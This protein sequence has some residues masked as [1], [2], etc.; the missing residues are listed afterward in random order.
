METTREEALKKIEELVAKLGRYRQSGLI[1]RTG[2]EGTKKDF[3]TPLFRALGWDVENDKS[4]DEVI[5]EERVSK[6]RVD[7]SFRINGIP[8]FFLEAKA[9][10]K[11]LDEI[12]DSSQAINYAWHKGTS[13]AVLTDFQTLVIY[14]AEVKDNNLSNA[15]FKTLTFDQFVEHFE[16]LWLLSKPAFD[17]GLLDKAA[18]SWGKK[19]RK[20]KVGDQ[21]LSELMRHRTLLSKNIVKNNASKNLS[22]AEVDEAVQRIIDRLIFIRTAEDRNIEPPTLSPLVREIEDKKRGKAT[23]ALNGVYRKFD[24]TYNSKLFTFNASDLTQRHLCETLEIDNDTLLQVIKGLYSSLDGLTH[25]DFSAID[26][27]VLGNIYEQYLSHILK[28]TDKRAKVENREAHRKEQGIYYTPTYIVDYIV[29]NTLGEMLKN[30]KPAEADKLKVLDMA[31]GSGSFLLKAFDVLDEYYK[32]KDKNYAQSKLDART[33]ASRITRKTQILRNNIYGVD[34]D[35]KAVEI[36]QLNLLLKAAETRHRLPDLRENVKCGNSLID[37]PAIAGGRAFNWNDEFPEIM[38]DGGFDVIVGNPPYGAELKSAEMKYLQRKYPLNAGRLDT[39]LLFIE[40]AV[41]C[42]K[43]G[44]YLGFIVPV[45]WIVGTYSRKLREYLLS[46]TNIVQI[47]YFSSHVFSDAKIDTIIIILKKTRKLEHTR[48]TFAKEFSTI[49]NAEVHF[50]QEAWL[51]GNFEFYIFLDTQSKKLI[52]KMDT[53]GTRLGNLTTGFLGIQAY[54]KSTDRI[55]LGELVS[56]EGGIGF[57]PE[58]S[59]EHFNR[60]ALS[61]PSN[62]YV[63]YCNELY[64]ARKKTDFKQ[65]KILVRRILKDRIIAALDVE[66][67]YSSDM[68]YNLI[69]NDQSD[70]KWLLGLLNSKL[71]SFYYA[72]KNFDLS[73]TFPKLRVVAFK[74]LPIIRPSPERASE[75]AKLVDIQGLL[76][77]KKQANV[78]SLQEI[79]NQANE[80]DAKIDS[81]VYDLYGLTAEERKIVEEAVK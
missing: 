19:L 63:K 75:I 51:S 33:E 46:N 17:E 49:P 39:A 79:A 69:P 22:E 61:W 60:Y 52:A 12:K 10:N 38:K 29:R 76:K 64:S 14:N 36:A 67:Q 42:L 24:E 6:G 37:D 78:D 28:K 21:L 7:Y 68:V 70:G 80:V 66:G 5:N 65:Q 32:K 41:S 54:E 4:L 50:D 48:V 43:T 23:A 18:L 74:E 58:I 11:G 1:A 26:A 15:R 40:R 53:K 35:P 59:G 73:A 9:L 16:E 71:L 81:L 30:K 47:V 20:T 31:C 13:W 62:L 34:L 57:E 2:E 8:K 3:I 72:K 55:K 44:G 45:R 56:K 25:Y 77:N 27:D